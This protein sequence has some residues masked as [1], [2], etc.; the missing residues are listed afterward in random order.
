MPSTGAGALRRGRGERSLWLLPRRTH[1]SF[2][3]CFLGQQSTVR[4]HICATLQEQHQN[5]TADLCCFGNYTAPVLAT[6]GSAAPTSCQAAPATP[7]AAPSRAHQQHSLPHPASFLLRKLQFWRSNCSSRAAPAAP[8]GPNP[9]QDLNIFW[10]PCNTS[11][12]KALHSRRCWS[13]HRGAPSQLHP[14]PKMLGRF[15]PFRPHRAVPVVGAQR[16][17]GRHAPTAILQAL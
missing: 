3:S 11:E 8:R 15:Q 1:S 5:T 16:S 2:F 13:T 4:G 14:N 12:L 6:G 7:A 10:I 9:A 17:H